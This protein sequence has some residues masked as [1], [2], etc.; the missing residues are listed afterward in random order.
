MNKNLHTVTDLEI[1]IAELQRTVKALQLEN[2]RLA[3]ELHKTRMSNKIAE[4]LRAPR[5][6]AEGITI[7]R[8]KHVE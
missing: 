7:R 5:T 8:R 1:A 6:P 2:F 4:A 3:E